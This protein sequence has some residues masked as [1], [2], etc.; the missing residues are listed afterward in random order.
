MSDCREK[1]T[2]ECCTKRGI[3]PFFGRVE[4]HVLLFVHELVVK[5]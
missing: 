4:N 3:P 2:H 1:T 5:K